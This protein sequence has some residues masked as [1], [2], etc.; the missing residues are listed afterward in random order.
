MPPL[1]RRAVLPL[2][3][4]LASLAHAAPLSFT[5]ALDLAE[6]LSPKLAA[7]TAMI[8]AARSAAIPAGALPDPKVFAGIDNFPVSGPDAGRLQAD[9]MTMQKIGVLQEVPNKDKRR[10][11]EAV[12]AAGVGVVTAQRR[13]DRLGV[14]RDT[15]QAWLALYHLQRKEALFRDLA[16]E[17]TMLAQI[18]QARIA[19]GRA[20]AADAVAPKQEAAQ[21][22]DR[23]DDWARDEE[24]ARSKLRQFVGV[25]ASDG[26]AGDPP[27]FDIDAQQLR[28]H[29]HQHPELLAF[30]AET[31][32]A[33]AE[34]AQ[35][36]S[37]KKSDWGVE[38]AYQRRGPQFGNMV[39]IQF[40]FDLP[41]SPT[42]RQDPLIAAKQHE[43]DRIDAER[44]GMVRDHASELDSLLAEYAAL[45]RQLERAQ[46][47]ALPLAERK[48]SL[49]TTSYQAGKSD[50]SA[51]LATRRERID[52]RMRIVD[53]EAALARAVAR[54]HYAYGQDGQ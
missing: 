29:L 48:V 16:H 37:M 23:R 7:N 54:L 8:D 32:K 12:A 25:A 20:Q 31:Q 9:F 18:V 28:G 30:A 51:V 2:L 38:L 40:T 35:A 33:E 1:I 10:A 4:G 19:S 45:T 3:A 43:V 13:V 39:S 22:E 6:R 26:L 14:R 53:L 52:Q 36:R 15:A 50:L 27:A 44:N 17:N 46:Q 41:L 42:T 11:R 5:T 34:V 47:T 21:L 24:Q 49:Q